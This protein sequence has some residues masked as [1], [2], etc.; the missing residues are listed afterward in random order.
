MHKNML[1]NTLILPHITYDIIVGGY[2]GNRLNKIQKRA[3][4]IIT[5]SRYNSHTEPLL[6]QLNLLKL[7][8]ILKLQ[9]FKFYFKFNEGSLRV[10]LQ[11]W[12]ITTNAHV[13]NYT[14]REFACIHTFK[15][16]HQF[17]KNNSQ[18]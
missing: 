2:Q 3:I 6:K 5:S 18:I 7:D 10:Y 16:K 11:N 4:R 17:A 15:V 1:Y 13:I 8:D 14:T 12:D 9:Q